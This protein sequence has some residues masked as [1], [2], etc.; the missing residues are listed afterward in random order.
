MP[1]LDVKSLAIS[2]AGALRALAG[3]ALASA[4]IVI[5]EPAPAD[6]LIMGLGLAMLLLGYGRIGPVALTCG[7][8]WIVV[9]VAGLAATPMSPGFSE[10]VRF[11]IVTLYLVVAAF[12]LAAFVAVDPERNFHLLARAYLVGIVVA[13]VMGIAL[14]PYIVGQPYR[15]RHLR[16]ALEEIAAARSDIWL[17][18]AGAIARHCERLAPGVVA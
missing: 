2:P 4:S 10:A 12:A 7:M 8:L 18:S 16:A 17:T 6:A 1:V 13:L 5:W 9:V 3:L 11:Q 15:L 14:H